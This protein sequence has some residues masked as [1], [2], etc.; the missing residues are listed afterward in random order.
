MP[1]EAEAPEQLGYERIRSNLTESSVRDRSLDELGLELGG[2]SLCY[3]EHRGHPGLRELVAAA[4]GAP[5]AA[6]DVLLAAGASSALFM[7][8]MA[9]LERGSHM[10]V[11]RPNYGTNIE[12]PRG[13]GCEVELIDLRFEEGYALDPGRV[14]ALLRRDTRLVSV[15]TP[16]NPTGA[17][18]ERAALLELV[19]L[20][21]AR[22]VR[23]LVDETYR[24]L[25]FVEPLPVAAG[26]S[27]NAI[28]VSS[29][30]KAYGLPG[31]RL[32]WLSAAIRRSCTSCSASR[33]RSASAAACWTRRSGITPIR[34]ARSG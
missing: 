33:S 10:I 24:D 8:A 27:T 12:T 28:S 4:A 15:T 30:S 21:E 13:L 19:R 34:R 25:S 18:M 6:G 1:I 23:L 22:G 26:L 20:C 7:V 17:G 29:M 9:L 11:V 31:I 32:G 3:S 16:H 2:L 5:V 14:A